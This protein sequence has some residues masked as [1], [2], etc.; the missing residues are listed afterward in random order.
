MSTSSDTTRRWVATLIVLLLLA[1]GGTW[2]WHKFRQM[3]Q[4]PVRQ[5]TE[6]ALQRKIAASMA[7]DTAL[8]R[9]DSLLTAA[10]TLAAT[11]LLDS[12]RRQPT[13]SLFPIERQK[14]RQIQARLTRAQPA[15]APAAPEPR[16]TGRSAE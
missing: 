8:L 3:Q 7:Y 2:L 1:Q 10:D 11:Q 5:A 4:Q 15:T 12:L 13:D 6:A 16:G 9:A 14:L